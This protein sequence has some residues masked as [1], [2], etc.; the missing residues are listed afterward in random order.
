MKPNNQVQTNGTSCNKPN[1]SSLPAEDSVLEPTPST[2]DNVSKRKSNSEM[3]D[4][5]PVPKKL[6]NASNKLS[7]TSSKKL[8][9]F[10]FTKRSK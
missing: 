4:N 10:A 7:D 5:V 2:S 1:G 6:K 8:T 9:Q 3:E